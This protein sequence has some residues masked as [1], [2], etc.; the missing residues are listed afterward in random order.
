M[1]EFPKEIVEIHRLV[2]SHTAWR[3][4]TIN[5]IASENSLSPAVMDALNNDWLGRYAD[6]TGRDLQ[7]RRYKGTRYMIEIE[8]I[9]EALVKRLFHVDYVELR[10]IS[11]HLAGAAV[12][13]ALC[14]PG[15][16][17]FELGGDSGGHREA[18]KLAVPSLNKLDVRF[19]PFDGERYNIDVPAATKMI[20]ELKP[21]IIILG[22]SNLL[23]PHPV[24]E[25]KQ[26]L[27]NANPQGILVY[28][29]SHVLG[30]L[31]GGSFQDPLREGADLIFSSTHKTFPGPQGGIIVTNKAEL[32]EPISQA[33]Y[34]ALV[35]NHHPFRMPALAIALTEMEK[36]GASYA[37][38]I[39]LNS[40]EFG[41]ALES[42][43][44]P[45]VKWNGIYSHSHTVLARVVDFGQGAEIAS[46]LESADIICTAA[47]L[48]H[49]QGGEG[50][51]LGIQE[52][53]HQGAF[54][55]DMRRVAALIADVIL[56]RRPVDLVR[57]AVRAFTNQSR[58]F[59]YSF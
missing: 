12:L 5:L 52:L 27:I 33:I 23:F 58:S 41:S 32:I 47:G 15:D 54:E 42:E 3:R 8:K 45:C 49:E 57:E 14:Q 56:E 39:G 50:I 26:T 21:K 4:R 37:Q 34:P 6:F 55:E 18:T 11:G 30:L 29:A 19:I 10:P 25:I 1:T 16:V 36:F 24:Q 9:V 40:Q 20:M 31:A 38:Q 43:G 59:P 2:E 35:T 13:M 51:R 46:R 7:A 28:D 44:V 53:T 48:P 22:S 17:V